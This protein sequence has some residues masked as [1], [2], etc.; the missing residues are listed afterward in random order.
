MAFK[1]LH[2]TVDEFDDIL[3]EYAVLSGLGMLCDLTDS[4]TPF[5]I[6]AL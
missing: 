1:S 3:G 5:R 4:L 6:H 2:L